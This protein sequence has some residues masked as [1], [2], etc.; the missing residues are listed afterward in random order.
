[1]VSTDGTATAFVLALAGGTGSGKSTLARSLSAEQ[2]P[3]ATILAADAFYRDLAHLPFYQRDQQDFDHP[4]A[5][6]EPAL[7]AALTHLKSG[8]PAL[9]PEYDFT[10]HT[11]RPALRVLR[12]T[13]WIIVEGIFILMMPSLKPLIDLSLFVDTPE[14]ECR[15]RRLERDPAARCRLDQRERERWDAFV[16]PSW[17]R[18]IEP[19]RQRATYCLDGQQAPE[20]LLEEA[21]GKIEALAG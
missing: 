11:R 13:P 7:A 16:A 19:S 20:A 14:P 6:D 18:W 4:Q 3:S 10:T 1:M 21:L 9:V 17:P 2:Q 15:R 12:P 5:I 8:K